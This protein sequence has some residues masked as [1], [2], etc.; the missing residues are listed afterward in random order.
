MYSPIGKTLAEVAKDYGASLQ[1]YA[2]FVLEDE[3]DTVGIQIGKEMIMNFSI[4]TI[5]RKYPEY[6]NYKVKYTND[7]LGETVFRVIKEGA[8]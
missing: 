2:V 1:G 8:E 3:N 7:F 4:R 6:S 5:L